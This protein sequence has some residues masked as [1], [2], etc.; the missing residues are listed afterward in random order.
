MSR[1][2]RVRCFIALI[3]VI[4]AAMNSPVT[5]DSIDDAEA[6]KQGVSVEQVQLERAQ[7]R[8]KELETQVAQLKSQL[9]ASATQPA[10][11]KPAASPAT[12]KHSFVPTDSFTSRSKTRQPDLRAPVNVHSP[13]LNVG[14]AQKIDQRIAAYLL[15]HPDISD[16]MAAAMYAGT[17]K[18]G[19]TEE[20]V[21]LYCRVD[22]INS[23]SL[24]SKTVTVEPLDSLPPL[25]QPPY[26]GAEDPQVSVYYR[27]F[28]L[29]ILKNGVVKQ[30]DTD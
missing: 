15:V 19:M 16:A 9:A 29:L 1:A 5:A 6:K 28:R 13:V 10:A 7:Q 2:E 22:V 26:F 25:P 14:E 11:A 3:L 18:P 4:G 20:Q 27:R 24:V 17:P 8:I 12:A 30:V 23:E 21:M